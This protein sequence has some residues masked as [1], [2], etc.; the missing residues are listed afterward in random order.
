M[1]IIVDC[2][3]DLPVLR[4]VDV[5]CFIGCVSVSCVLLLLDCCYVRVFVDDINI[6]NVNVYDRG[7]CVPLCVFVIVS[8]MCVSVIV[9]C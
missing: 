7:L 2:A 5:F 3:Y 4:V 8:C 1:C 9:V 6:I